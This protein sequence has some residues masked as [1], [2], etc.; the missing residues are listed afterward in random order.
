MLEQSFWPTSTT[1]PG[2]VGWLKNQ[3]QTYTKHVVIFGVVWWIYDEHIISNKSKTR[4]NEQRVLLAP[5]LH[6][7][8]K[9][10]HLNS[11]FPRLYTWKSTNKSQVSELLV[12]KSLK[13]FDQFRQKAKF[14]SNTK[15]SRPEKPSM[16][17]TETFGISLFS[18]VPFNGAAVQ[19]KAH[20]DASEMHDFDFGWPRHPGISERR[21]VARDIQHPA[22][23][24]SLSMHREIDSILYIDSIHLYET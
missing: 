24:D 18:V 14:Q 19:A 5:N 10:E 1:S 16:K 23:V 2:E 20:C 12:S 21:D 3:Y 13:F 6:S 7:L 15:T 4:D 11:N 8:R 17:T 22:A 9:I